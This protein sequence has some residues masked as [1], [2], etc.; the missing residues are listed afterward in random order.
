MEMNY[1]VSREIGRMSERNDEKVIWRQR[2]PVTGFARY[3]KI[4]KSKMLAIKRNVV[5]SR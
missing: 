2:K 4:T 1:A 5:V 3:A